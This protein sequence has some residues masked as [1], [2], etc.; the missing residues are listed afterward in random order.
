MQA[1]EPDVQCETL[2]VDQ[3]VTGIE[4]YTNSQ[5]GVL[6]FSMF[7]HNGATYRAA[8][9]GSGQFTTSGR[10]DFSG[11]PIGM[12]MLF[13]DAPGNGGSWDPRPDTPFAI[14]TIIDSEVCDFSFYLGGQG[15]RDMN[16]ESVSGAPDIQVVVN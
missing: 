16:T 11:P 3:W 12:N 7:G 2:Q 5:L 10:I 14:Q 13:T 1:S 9:L 4:Y 15:P 6:G 8:A